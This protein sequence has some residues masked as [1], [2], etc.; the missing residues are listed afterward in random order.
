MGS[1]YAASIPLFPTELMLTKLDLDTP[2]GKLEVVQI[3]KRRK[4]VWKELQNY[5]EER[6]ERKSMNS[7]GILRT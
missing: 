5:V 6:V 1:I 4:V 7:L 2:L 3:M